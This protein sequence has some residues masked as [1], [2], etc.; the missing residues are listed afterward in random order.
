MSSLTDHQTKK[1]IREVVREAFDR[2]GGADWLVT[3]A[4]ASSENARVFVSLVG[5]LIPT[6]LVGKNGGPLTVVIKKETDVDT[7]AIL[8][9]VVTRL[10][11]GPR[12][13]N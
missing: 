12:Q 11:D 10:D 2:L 6:E 8:E 13:L 7:A 1:A 5:R 3:F 9:G 4:Q